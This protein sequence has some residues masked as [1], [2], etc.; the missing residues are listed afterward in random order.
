MTTSDPRFRP[1]LP[2]R[3][4]SCGFRCRWCRPLLDDVRYYLPDDLPP[5]AGQ[6]L[7]G[8]SR[9]RVDKIPG[10]PRTALWRALD[11]LGQWWVSPP[12]S[13][14]TRPRRSD[15]RGRPA[16]LTSSAT[17]PS[18]P[19]CSAIRC[20]RSA[21]RARRQTDS[22]SRPARPIFRGGIYGVGVRSIC[23]P[24]LLLCRATTIGTFIS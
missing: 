19:G 24:R 8:L 21:R 12:P 7:R 22:H 20:R 17:W 11:V 4:P 23:V 16:S 6:D 5:L 3:P 13:R 1:A 15:Q 14:A 18:W 2:R 10:D 9:P